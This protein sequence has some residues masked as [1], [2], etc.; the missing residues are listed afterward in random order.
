MLQKSCSSVGCCCVAAKASLAHV[1]STAHR[2][3]ARIRQQTSQ[4]SNALTTAQLTRLSAITPFVPTD[5]LGM[6]VAMRR[7]VLAE[8]VEYVLQGH[9][10]PDDGESTVYLLTCM[11]PQS[12]RGLLV[13]VLG[14]Q[15]R[16]MRR[17]VRCA[18]VPAPPA[19]TARVCHGQGVCLMDAQSSH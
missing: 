7:Q 17:Q 18:R 15:A 2:P 12:S 3:L 1:L 10:P 16:M 13:R 6:P 14:V 9:P 19:M 8:V 11:H 5:W 4:H